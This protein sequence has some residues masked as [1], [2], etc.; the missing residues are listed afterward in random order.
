[1]R[2]YRIG[3]GTPQLVRPKLVGDRH[4][5]DRTNPQPPCIVLEVNETTIFADKSHP[6]HLQFVET[7]R[8]AAFDLLREH[9]HADSVVVTNTTAQQFHRYKQTDRLSEAMH[10][11]SLAAGKRTYT[12]Q[13]YFKEDE[14]LWAFAHHATVREASD[15]VDTYNG[16]VNRE[17]RWEHYGFTLF[18]AAQS[19]MRK[20]RAQGDMPATPTFPEQTRLP[21]A[22]G[23]RVATISAIT[24][25]SPTSETSAVLFAEGMYVIIPES[26]PTSCKL[27]VSPLLCWAGYMDETGL[28]HHFIARPAITAA[29][30]WANYEALGTDALRL[31]D[32]L[33]QIEGAL[34]K[35]RRT[36]DQSN[37]MEAYYLHHCELCQFVGCLDAGTHAR[38]DFY[39]CTKRPVPEVLAR[40]G[41]AHGGFYHDAYH[42]ARMESLSDTSV[43]QLLSHGAEL[44]HA[45]RLT[46][47]YDQHPGRVFNVVIQDVEGRVATETLTQKLGRI[48]G[49]GAKAPDAILVATPEHAGFT[50]RLLEQVIP[51][52]G[53]TVVYTHKREGEDL[54]L[55]DTRQYERYKARLVGS[56]DE[57]NLYVF[58]EG[59]GF[60]IVPDEETRHGFLMWGELSLF[61][62]ES[63]LHRV[64]AP[65]FLTND[66][67]LANAVKGTIGEK[68]R[69]LNSK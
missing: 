46:A 64:A 17:P 5:A 12:A 48:L 8:R 15:V 32:T 58:I 16:L 29:Q 24:P 54:Y 6:E 57:E 42:D 40:Y 56:V 30:A 26:F 59:L 10:G 47:L 43:A 11:F 2:I 37:K 53:I 68:R 41:N 21:E 28:E 39:F 19:I 45:K 3:D 34:I 14:A 36:A 27:S 55:I 23:M 44:A 52:S 7:V 31:P 22:S 4:P 1:M 63:R 20:L 51:N 69:N 9:P 67:R 65:E 35:R 49:E 13:D 61:Q 60:R 50:R 66:E 18:C 25:L 62:P 38:V 33:V